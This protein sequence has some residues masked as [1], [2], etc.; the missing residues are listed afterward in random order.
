MFWKR[1]VN[2]TISVFYTTKFNLILARVE[3]LRPL[4]DPST[5]FSTFDKGVKRISIDTAEKDRLKISKFTE[6]K[7]DTSELKGAKILLQKFA[8]FYRDVLYGGGHK[9]S[10]TS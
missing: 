5:V 4:V 6:F 8:K 2:E 1:P 3:S 9:L 7:G 10:Q